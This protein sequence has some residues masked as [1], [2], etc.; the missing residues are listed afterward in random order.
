MRN[1]LLRR[2]GTAALLGV[3]LLGLAWTTPQDQPTRLVTH[4]WIQ[5][6]GM[7]T[8]AHGQT[9]R[10]HV[11]HLGLVAP[12]DPDRPGDVS[13]PDPETPPDPCRVLLAFHDA[14]G[15]LIGSPVSRILEGGKSTFIDLSFIAPTT[16]AVPP[17]PCRATVW[18]F[19][20]GP[21][22]LAP[23]DPCKATLELLDT[24]SGKVQLH[25]LPAVQHALPAVQ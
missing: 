20:R 11:V 22:G 21:R 3:A 17:D 7:V 15:N 4:R 9:L 24:T 2:G 18:V 19:Q 1:G 16:G 10:L 14:A 12:P 8:P 25:M 5:Q 23:P 13:P 6:F